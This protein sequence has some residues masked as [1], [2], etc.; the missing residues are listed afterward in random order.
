[1][2]GNAQPRSLVRVHRLTSVVGVRA[3]VSL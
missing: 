3:F 2:D 1:V